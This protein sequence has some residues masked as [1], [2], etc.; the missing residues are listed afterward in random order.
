MNKQFII[1][2]ALILFVSVGIF[3][4][5]S[6]HP[7]IDLYLAGKKPEA[8][9]SLTKAVK[10][11]E[12][13]KNG[14]IWNYLGLSYIGVS[15]NKN[16]RKALEKAVKL[17]PTNS[18]YRSNLAYAYLL[19]NETGK[20]QSESKKAIELD[21]KNVTAYYL[22]GSASLWGGKFDDAQADAEQMMTIDPTYGQAYVLKSHVLVGRLGQKVTKGS[23]VKAEIDLL[24]D[25]TD[26]LRVGL[27][28]TKK[29]PSGKLVE[30]ELESVEAFYS[31]FSKERP[32]V[33]DPIAVPEPGVVQLKIVAKPRPVYTDQARS[34]N[35]QGTISVAVLFAANGTIKNV[36]LLKRLGSGL[37]EQAMRAA[38]K[39][40][41]EPMTRDSK[42]ISVVKIVEYSFAIY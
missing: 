7:G 12:F 36:M 11:K 24:R 30:E 10:Q 13:E 4:Q 5:S 3:A 15:D 1:I 39:I 25:A 27:E 9:S 6:S 18:T 19:L 33:P 8:V 16:A 35:V 26:N 38:R 31:Y 17:T 14:E 42:P 34:G 23:T 41:F 2:F 29:S 22:R 21:S 40:D 28:Q 20:A 37:D 32:I